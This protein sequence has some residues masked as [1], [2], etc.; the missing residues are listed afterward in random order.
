MEHLINLLNTPKEFVKQLC[1]A[2]ELLNDAPHFYNY[3]R[4]IHEE[5]TE[6]IENDAVGAHTANR[7]LLVDD[8]CDSLWVIC[9]KLHHTDI[10]QAISDYRHLKS[11]KNYQR[12]NSMLISNIAH[13]KYERDYVTVVTQLLILAHY[14]AINIEKAFSALIKE[15]MS[16]LDYPL[17]MINEV[18]RDGKL[19]KKDFNDKLYPW[20]KPADFSVF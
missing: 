5:L 2:F 12:N 13:Y 15:N 10:R 8:I 6:L 7:A 16:K 19:Q 14:N 20:Y 17:G 11:T 9:A 1:F 3:P 4:F 18:L